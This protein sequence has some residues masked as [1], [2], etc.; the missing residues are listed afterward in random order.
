MVEW[1]TKGVLRDT[2]RTCVTIEGAQVSS[3]VRDRGTSALSVAHARKFAARIKRMAVEF[4]RQEQVAAPA[5]ARSVN[6]RILAL[7]GLRKAGAI[8]EDEYSAKKAELLAQL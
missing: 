2:R 3:A 5:G 4:A 7:D 6:E 8:T 1:G